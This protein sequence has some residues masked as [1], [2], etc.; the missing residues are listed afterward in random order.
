MSRLNYTMGK[1]IPIGALLV[2]VNMDNIKSMSTML[3]IISLRY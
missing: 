1:L 2:S 3:K